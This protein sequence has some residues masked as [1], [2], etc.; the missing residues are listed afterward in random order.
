MTRR[1]LVTSSPLCQPMESAE[2][3]GYE[4][5]ILTRVPDMGDGMDRKSKRDSA[6]PSIMRKTSARNLRAR[7]DSTASVTTLENS[8]G[9][10]VVP[11]T[12]LARTESGGTTGTG[13]RPSSPGGSPKI[14]YREQ[15]V[16]EVLQL[17]LYQAI[18][19]GD[20]PPNAT[21]VL[22]TGD[23]RAGQFNEEGF[24]GCI[25]IALKKGWRV[26]LYSWEDGLS[27]SWKRE[28]GEGPYKHLFS[29]HGLSD[30]GQD[31]LE[32]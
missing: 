1:V 19:D 4:V 10:N 12:P 18:A 17:K 26:E 24:I 11:P 28:F 15:G 3:L 20:A 29:I 22:A 27:R 32:E 7:R 2:Q 9:I 14:R 25:R 8:E 16:D 13:S 6:G 21:I 23:G 31:L 5:R 30:F